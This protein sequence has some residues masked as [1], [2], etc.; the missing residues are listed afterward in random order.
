MESDPKG[1]A[2]VVRPWNR[3][4]RRC[5]LHTGGHK[6]EFGLGPDGELLLIDEVHTPDSSRYWATESLD[7]R[8]AEGRTP[9]SF[10]KEPVRLALAAAGYRGDGPP[11]DLSAEVQADTTSRYV[12]LYERLTGLAFEPGSQP[13]E[14]R[15]LANLSS[16]LDKTQ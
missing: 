16:V 4:R 5:R 12:E 1:G 3:Y 10:D 11:P 2:G 8:L 7:E 6:Y 13:I 14:A 9:E 15:I